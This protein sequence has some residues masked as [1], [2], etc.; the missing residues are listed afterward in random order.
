MDEHSSEGSGSKEMSPLIDLTGI[1]LEDVA[2]LDDS[3]LV[4][5][6]NRV[7]GDIRNPDNV[8]LASFSA[9]I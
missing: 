1:S 2:Q 5:S 8:V 9:I 6:L 4:R 3:V 7:L